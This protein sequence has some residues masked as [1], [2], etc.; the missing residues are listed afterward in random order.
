MSRGL[1]DKN[2]LRPS[3]GWKNNM[4]KCSVLEIFFRIHIRNDSYVVQMDV[5]GYPETLVPKCQIAWRCF[6]QV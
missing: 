4:T 1:V 3:S 6:L 5:A 2:L